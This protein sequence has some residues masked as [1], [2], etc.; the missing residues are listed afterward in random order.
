M[1]DC[2][3][4]PEQCYTEKT[5]KEPPPY[6]TKAQNIW[7]ADA[8]WWREGLYKYYNQILSVGHEARAHFGIGMRA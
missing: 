1:G 3:L 8:P 6:V 5:G 4:E 7:P 2:Y